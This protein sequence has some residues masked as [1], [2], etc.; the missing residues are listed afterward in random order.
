MNNI[1]GKKTRIS[2]NK[3]SAKEIIF[4]PER[5]HNF[6]A[7]TTSSSNYMKKLVNFIR[8]NVGRKSVPSNYNHSMQEK[9]KSMETIYQETFSNFETKEG[10]IKRPVVYANASELLEFVF[11]Q[12]NVEAIHETKIKLLADGGQHFF[13][14]SL[15]IL[16]EEKENDSIDCE[17]KNVSFYSSGGNIGNKRK[18]NSVNRLII[19][20]IVPEIKETYDNLKTLVHLTKLN[21]IPFKFASDFKLILMFNGQQTASATYPCPYCFITLG[22]L[23]GFNEIY[24]ENDSKT[25]GD[26]YFNLKTYKNLKDD[27]LHFQRIGCD[28]KRSK[29]SHSTVNFPLF[30]EENNDD[31]DNTYVIEKSVPP[32]LHLLLGFVNH[33]FWNGIVKVVGRDKALLWPK[34]LSIIHKNYQGDAF[35]GNQCRKLLKA[36][37][38]LQDPIIYENVGPFRLLPYIASLK[39]MN[40]IVES[41]FTAKKV[42]LSDFDKNISELRNALKSTDVSQTIKIHVILDHLKQAIMLINNDGLGLWSEQAGESIHREF[43][44]FWDKFKINS[45]EDP[46]YQNRLKKAVVSFSSLHI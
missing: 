37:D 9:Q 5:F 20:C 7:N 44:K 32:E 17:S 27:Y 36:A 14:I 18:L 8:S 1:T 46:S 35:E 29:E 43:V 40:K 41:C 45:I 10:I 26:Q 33:L 24:E 30:A 22:E 6:Q 28:K 3:K 15:S 42:D 13:K 12:R 16:S 39:A 11:E 19:L 4:S 31:F 34:K 23:V 21:E 2:I 25:D 38:A